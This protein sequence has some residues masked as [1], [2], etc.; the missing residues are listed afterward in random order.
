MKSILRELLKMTSSVYPQSPSTGL[1]P[2]LKHELKTRDLQ[3][4]VNLPVQKTIGE[5]ELETIV[6][7]M[8]LMRKR[9]L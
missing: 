5:L 4:A 6:S 2:I 8:R 1:F 3:I 7:F 9:R